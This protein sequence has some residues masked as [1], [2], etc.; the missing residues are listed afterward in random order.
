MIFSLP[1]S[2]VKKDIIITEVDYLYH[3]PEGVPLLLLC[4]DNYVKLYL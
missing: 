1:Y 3:N 4:F 2:A